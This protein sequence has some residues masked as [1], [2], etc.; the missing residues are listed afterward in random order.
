MAERWRL[1]NN[2]AEPNEYLG[3]ELSGSRITPT[4]QIL[5]DEVKSKNLIL[6]FLVET[7]AYSS[8]IMGF[9]RKLEMTQGINVPHDSKSGE[10]AMIWKEGVDI[11][12]KSCS[13]LHIDMVV[14][15]EKG[16][17]PWRVIGFYGHPDAR[18]RSISWS[19]LETLK[20]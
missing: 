3:L 19:L 20:N 9:M 7:K 5:T 1:R 8:K 13:N 15:D 6:V 10:L 16:Q 4:I 12:F 2:A 11:R 14:Y 18:K 17:N